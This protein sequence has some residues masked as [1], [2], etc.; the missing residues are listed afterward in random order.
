[1]ASPDAI[2]P[3]PSPTHS[4]G[5][6]IELGHRARLHGASSALQHP[7]GFWPESRSLSFRQATTRTRNIA[8]NSV[9]YITPRT[10][11]AAGHGGASGRFEA[12]K[13]LALDFAFALKIAGRSDPA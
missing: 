1:M 3:P 2:P 10:N 6:G 8:S 5:S 7:L 11:M 13:E 9:L 12:L 4:A